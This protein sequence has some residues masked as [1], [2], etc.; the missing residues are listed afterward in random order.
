MATTAP[1]PALNAVVW[2]LVALGAVLAVV[3]VALFFLAGPGMLVLI[4]GGA[5]A[6][7]GLVIRA[8]A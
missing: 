6:V 3:G 5:L 2:T 4:A 1:S 8:A 7:L